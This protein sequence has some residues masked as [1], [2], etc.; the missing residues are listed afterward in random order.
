MHRWGGHDH[1]VATSGVEH[2]VNALSWA[3]H[4]DP[5]HIRAYLP[6]FTLERLPNLAKALPH[7][8]DQEPILVVYLNGN[9]C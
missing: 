8:W 5:L 3:K 7:F 9:V 2:R 6:P 1:P 4:G